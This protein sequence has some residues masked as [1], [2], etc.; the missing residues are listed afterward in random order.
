MYTK[1]RDRLRPVVG[2]PGIDEW[3]DSLD[4]DLEKADVSMQDSPSIPS[5]VGRDRNEHPKL[6]RGYIGYA[7]ADWKVDEGGMIALDGSHELTTS[8]IFTITK[9]QHV[10][11]ENSVDVYHILLHFSLKSRVN[12]NTFVDAWRNAVDAHTL[13]LSRQINAQ[14]LENTITEL[15][16][17][18]RLNSIAEEQLQLFLESYL[19]NL[20]TSQDGDDNPF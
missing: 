9:W 19:S 1:I 16:N 6:R 18:G 20:N 15:M 11:P 4:R 3:F 12:L 7:N 17:T 13:P 10:N 5:K 14:I 8:E 2:S